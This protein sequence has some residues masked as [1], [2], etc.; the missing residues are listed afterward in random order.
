MKATSIF[1]GV[2]FITILLSIVKSKL[3]ALILGPEGL[4][5][6]ALLSSTIGLIGGLTYFGLGTSA[7][8][9]V[10]QAYGKGDIERASFVIT[11]L[12]RCVWATGLLGM[13]VAICASSLLSRLT[14]G[15]SDYTWTFIWISTSLLFTQLSTGHLVILQGM[16]KL[17]YL[18]KSSLLGS[19]LGLLITVPLYYYFG[20]KGVVPGIILNAGLILICAWFFSK[21]VLLPKVKVSRLST[22]LEGKDMLKMGFFISL[23]GFLVLGSSYLVQ[24]YISRTK[25]VNDVGLYT[26]GFAIVNTYV[27]LIFNALATE[28]Y[29]RLSAVAHNNELSKNFINQQAE[30]TMMVLAPGIMMFLVFINWVILILYSD[31]FIT[32]EPMIHWAALGMLFKAASWPI[33]FIFLAK[34]NSKIFFWNDFVTIIYVL[35][36]NILGYHYLGLTGLG[37]SFLLAYIIYLFQVLIITK[38]KYDFNFSI[39][40]LYVFSLQLLLAILCFATM[41]FIGKPYSFIFGVFLI[42]VSSFISF[43]E[44]DKRMNLISLIRSKIGL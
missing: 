36:L 34:G 35:V 11:I 13:I 27:S 28:Y 44:L 29:P 23:S 24:I 19:F 18:A 8:K 43:R 21:K 1:G 41:T 15:N 12:K 17:E 10:S 6:S 7:V 42:L 30:I 26:A 25:G 33:S 40:F 4:G 20:I 32:I 9:N 31:K 16:R 37:F 39:G 14:F 2:Q 22:I 38:I 3:I 5:F